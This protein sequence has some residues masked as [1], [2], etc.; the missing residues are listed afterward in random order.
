MK[1]KTGFFAA[2]SDSLC[3]VCVYWIA[4]STLVLADRGWSLALVWPLLWTVLSAAVFVRVLAKP[5][6]FNAMVLLG[7][8][9]GAAALAL[10][11]AL[12]DKPLSALHVFTLA[13]GAGMS[14]GMPIYY[15]VRRPTLH[16]HLTCLD[17]LLLAFAWLLL[18]R[19]G[20]NAPAGAVVLTALVLVMAVGCAVGLRMGPDGG[21]DGAKAMGVAFAAALVL[22]LV[23]LLLIALFSRSGELTGGIVRALGDAARAIGR[24]ASWLVERF[25]MLF[26]PVDQGAGVP[27]TDT[28]LPEVS[29]QVAQEES[30]GSGVSVWVIV[31]LA[32]LPVAAVAAVMLALRKTKLTL[33][34]P[35]IAAASA[36]RTGRIRLG[37]RSRWA[38]FLAALGFCMTA[39]F[40]R[41]TPPGVLVYAHRRSA[42]RR[43]GRR[44]GETARQFL[45]RVAP[46]GALDALADDLDRRWYGGGKYTL[47]AAECR[48]LRQKIKEG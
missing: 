14:A 37:L 29:A 18:V 16:G 35:E 24:G 43:Q 8:L 44:S 25:A 28:A 7:A 40:R 6:S 45:R 46:D 20:Q 3:C 31:V 5:R 30:T 1:D 22:A 19:T 47:T 41:N 27:L 38:A 33:S 39:F 34:G 4:A 21:S 36:V 48:L 9:S 12:S 17:V 23:V 11:I 10:F 2:L 15:L 32:A 26:K 13:V 42:R